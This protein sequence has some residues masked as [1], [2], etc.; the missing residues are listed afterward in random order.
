[1]QQM[2]PSQDITPN[3][4]RPPLEADSGGSKFNQIKSTVAEKLVE[5]ADALRQKTGQEGAIAPYATQASDW[6]HQAADYVRDFDPAEV[7]TSLQRQV[8]NNPGRSLIAAAAV[9]LTLG[10]LLRRR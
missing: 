4:I 1:M 2:T 8:H 5:A 7:K 10:I 3:Q 6:L 9:G